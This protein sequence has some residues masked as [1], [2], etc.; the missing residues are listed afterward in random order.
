MGSRKVGLNQVWICLGCFERAMASVGEL[1]EEQRAALADYW[2]ARTRDEEK[3][4]Y[5]RMM[6]LGMPDSYC[7]SSG[8][9]SDA[10]HIPQ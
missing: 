7:A 10:R 8:E 3:A 4:A 9:L 5:A 6:A 1:T 2:A